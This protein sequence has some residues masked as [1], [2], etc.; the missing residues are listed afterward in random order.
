MRFQ[1]LSRH[2]DIGCNCYL[3]EFGGTRFVL[4]VGTH[5]K[6]SGNDTL[7]LFSEL[8]PDSLEA[9]FV[10]H[11]HL[12]HIGALPCL[13]EM[14]PD[15]TVI[16][17]EGTKHAG[18]ALLHNS[19]NVMTSM[20]KELNEPLY[21]LY[22]HRQVDSQCR[23]WMT[24]EIRSPFSLGESDRVECEFF[25]AGHVLGAV[26]IRFS[27]EGRT[28][29]YTG[30]V[31][32]E[33]Q[34]LTRGADLP[35]QGVD[36]LIIE[37]T[38]GDSERRA[39]YTREDEKRR[40]GEL[41][42]E[43]IANGGAVLIPVFAFGKT[44]EVV[45][46]LKELREAGAIPFCPV[47]IGGLSSKMT[48]ISDEHCHRPERHHQG[49]KILQE[50]PDLQV[51]SKGRA[52]PEYSPG[53]IYAL[54]SGM[55]SEKTVSNRFAKHILSSPRDALIF[56][57][58]ADPD[59]PAGRIQAA[60][61]GGSVVLEEKRNREVKVECRVERFDFSGHATR[62]MLVEYA[63]RLQPEEIILVHGDVPSREWLQRE[64]Q[65]RLPGAEV[66]IPEPGQSIPMGRR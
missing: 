26:G 7:P 15:A 58:Y 64:M 60:S 24:R 39:G 56:V 36:T 63:A 34:T 66:I 51:M 33:D 61:R 5:P 38:R 50:F 19:V 30:D 54:S 18:R 28:V 53:H 43:T 55:M 4:D 62:D 16:M 49:Y 23:H 31:H 1:N 46:M 65:A 48:A 6:H 17:T 11:P 37:S 41:I 3:L 47:H 25:H 42:A 22:S 35:G 27:F 10:S 29:F 52:E 13:S 12:D 45:L 40:M 44:Q 32:L 9:I 59:S 14:Q 2:R 21:P 20:G 8:R 57:G